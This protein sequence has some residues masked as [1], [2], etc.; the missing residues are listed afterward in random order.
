MKRLNPIQ[1][2]NLVS[3]YI[4]LNLDT[5][6]YHLAK[7][8]A[9]VQFA[10]CKVPSLHAYCLKL[11]F[12]MG[13]YSLN[14][15]S[16]SVSSW[17][18]MQPRILTLFNNE[19]TAKTILA[20]LNPSNDQLHQFQIK[21][22]DIIGSVLIIDMIRSIEQGIIEPLSCNSIINTIDFATLETG[23]VLAKDL[24]TFD[25]LLDPHITEQ[26][27]WIGMLHHTPKLTIK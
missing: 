7:G 4:W 26:N 10:N 3:K 1:V 13:V 20:P 23:Q 18:S 17:L 9:L 22:F 25:Y 24:I 6:E 16:K 12:A 2:F 19:L 5:S 8:N 27:T 15:P 14:T 11:R 21:F